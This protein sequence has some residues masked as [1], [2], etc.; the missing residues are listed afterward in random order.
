MGRASGHEP[1]GENKEFMQNFQQYPPN[2]SEN[3][4]ISGL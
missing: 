2:L 3:M 4:G 1:R